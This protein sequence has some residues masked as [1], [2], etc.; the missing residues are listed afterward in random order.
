MKEIKKNTAIMTTLITATSAISTRDLLSKEIMKNWGIIR[1]ENLIDK[2]ASR[3]YDMKALLNRIEK[4][5]KERI[6]MKLYTQLINMGFAKFSDLPKNSLY[7]IIFELSEKNEQFVQL[8]LIPTLDAKLKAKKGKAKISKT[9]ELTSAFIKQKR[10]KLQL[11]I[12]DLKKKIE[13]YNA[14][15]TLDIEEISVA[16]AA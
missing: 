8:G 3:N 11:E 6:K 16:L 4:L 2:N 12:N 10:E 15:A 1:S 9:E 14:T 5:A 7:P 13:N